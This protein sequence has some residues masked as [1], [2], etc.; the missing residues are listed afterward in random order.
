MALIKEG[1][2]SIVDGGTCRRRCLG[3]PWQSLWEER[4]KPLRQLYCHWTRVCC[5]WLVVVG[6]DPTDPIVVWKVLAN[7]YQRKTWANKLELKRKRKLFSMR[8]AEGGSV[9]ESND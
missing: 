7:Q 5:M 1:L 4:T 2:W 8:L 6:A 9:Q 3:E